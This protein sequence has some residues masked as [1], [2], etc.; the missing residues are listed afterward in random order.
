M[1]KNSFFHQYLKSANVN[2][3]TDEF[4]FQLESHPDYPSLLSFHDALN[5]FN[6]ANIATKI[7]DKEIEGLPDRFIGEVSIEGHG[8]K[9]TDVRKN[10]EGF[11]VFVDES[12]ILD[13]SVEKFRALWTGIVLAAEGNDNVDK[14]KAINSPILL[15]AVASV[16][17]LSFF[18][19]SYAVFL[20]LIFTGLFFA[21]EAIN[22]ELKIDTDFSSKICNATSLTDCDSVI[23]PDGLKLFGLFKFS[24]I[25]IVFFS[26]QLLSFSLFLILGVVP[27]FYLLSIPLFIIALPI[28]LFSIYYQWRISKKWCSI[29]LGIIVVL[30]SQA[31]FSFLQY[32]SSGL[33][34]FDFQSSLLI[35]YLAPFMFT[36]VAWPRLKSFLSES[37]NI[38]SERTS[39]F[40]FKRNYLVFKQQLKLGDRIDFDDLCSEITIGNKDSKLQI[41]LVTNPFCK[42]CKEIHFLLEELCNKY[43]DEVCLNI[44]FIFDPNSSS[45]NTAKDLHFKLVQIYFDEGESAFREALTYWFTY[46]DYSKWQ[47]KYTLSVHQSEIIHNLIEHQFKVNEAN[48]IMFTP[49]LFIGEYAF[50]GMYEKNDIQL[51]MSDL[52]EDADFLIEK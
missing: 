49:S 28:T 30:Y 20:L 18:S 7:N 10:N 41:S 24:D 13:V 19:I 50:P 29:C 51:F 47:R 31:P 34:E 36:L 27:D 22:K 14:R 9:L 1:K 33:K 43:P 32:T 6:V 26:G 38:K 46:K 48:N 21:K 3:D 17:L 2:L 5:F 16:L 37:Q 39:L 4:D 15:T 25:S 45:N 42:F 12:N 8:T 11:K 35:L 40:R 23:K 44:S 52:L